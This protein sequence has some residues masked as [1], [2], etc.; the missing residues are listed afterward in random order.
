MVVGIS[1]CGGL[2]TV[3]LLSLRRLWYR[4]FFRNLFSA[5]L[6]CGRGLHV[7]WLV[8]EILSSCGSSQRTKVASVIC[9]LFNPFTLAMSTRVASS[10]LYLPPCCLLYCFY[11]VGTLF[12]LVRSWLVIHLRIYRWSISYLCVAFSAWTAMSQMLILGI[13]GSKDRRIE[14]ELFC[15]IIKSSCRIFWP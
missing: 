11:W 8:L 13:E 5:T 4:T 2:H 14:D 6:F 1:P 12:L 15:I 10:R 7:E 9:W 3:I